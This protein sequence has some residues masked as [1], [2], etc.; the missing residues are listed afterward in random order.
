M[1]LAF[2]LE[3]EENGFFLTFIFSIQKLNNK[4]MV[5]I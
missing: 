3:E 5:I 4:F 1:G 2:D